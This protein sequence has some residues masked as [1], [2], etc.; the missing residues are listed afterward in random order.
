MSERIF[1]DTNI[2]VYAVDR[3]AGEKRKKAQKTVLSLWNQKERPFLSAQVL[4]EL[5][6]TF[7]KK[8]LSA[9][10]SQKIVNDYC[11]WNIIHLNE[12]LILSAIK[13]QIRWKISYWDAL[14]LA[15][16]QSVQADI[17]YSEDFEHKR[18]FGKIR[19]INPLLDN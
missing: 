9:Q 7:I 15:A 10:Q 11:Q 17:L 8:G 14:I 5:H 13:E 19:I 4:S 3:S 18:V 12:H 16:A 6:V 1:I 2:L